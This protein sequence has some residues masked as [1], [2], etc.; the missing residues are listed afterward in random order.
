M[1]ITCI[2]TWSRFLYLAVVMDARSRRIV[3]WPMATQLRIELAL[4]AL[5]VALGQQQPGDVIRYSDQSFRHTSIAF[6][7]R[8]RETGVRPSIG[9]VADCYGNAM[10]KSYFAT[11]E[12]ELLE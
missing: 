7:P 6:G 5:K 9:W 1:D 10:C 11:L 2:P 4:D 8:C 12:C 3:G